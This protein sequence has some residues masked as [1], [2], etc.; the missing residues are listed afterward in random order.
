LQKTLE[1]EVVGDNRV[2]PKV[3]GCGMSVTANPIEV[4][5]F[6]DIDAS[7]FLTVGGQLLLDQLTVEDHIEIVHNSWLVSRGAKVADMQEIKSNRWIRNT[8]NAPTVNAVRIP[9][10]GAA[11]FNPPCWNILHQDLPEGYVRV[12]L[13]RSD[14]FL[15]Q[16]EETGGKVF[17]LSKF[18]ELTQVGGVNHEREAFASLFKHSLMGNLRYFDQELHT[19]SHPVAANAK[20][21]Q[22]ESQGATLPEQEFFRI[23][24]TKRY[25]IPTMPDALYLTIVCDWTNKA[26]AEKYNLAEETVKKNRAALVREC[27]Y[28]PLDRLDPTIGAEYFG[29]DH[30]GKRTWHFQVRDKTMGGGIDPQQY[31]NGESD[32]PWR[33]WKLR[34]Q[35]RQA[36]KGTFE[37]DSRRKRRTSQP[38]RI[39]GGDV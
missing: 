13:P 30:V 33:E 6:L 16:D 23:I 31:A 38:T 24:R 12:P 14:F 7:P 19:S 17:E 29:G 37:S 27:G 11:P 1:D 26:A 5:E 32:D 15:R 28:E 8:I 25:R 20:K 2:H 22:R 9:V 21:L 3:C 18:Q 36:F 35:L 34:K 4:T 39:P 10:R